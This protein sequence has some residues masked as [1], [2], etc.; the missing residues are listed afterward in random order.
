MFLQYRKERTLVSETMQRL[1][2]RG[3]TTASGGNVSLR[4]GDRICITPSQTDKGK[5]RSSEIGIV[6]IEDENLTPKL[7][8]SMEL[9]MHLEIYKSRPDIKAIVH[10]H[11]FTATALA[12]EEGLL[13]TEITGEARAILGIPAFAKYQT[14]G[15]QEL[16][17]MVAEKAKSATVILMQHHGIITLGKNMLQAFDRME[18]LEMTAR[19]L[20]IRKLCGITAKIPDDQVKILDDMFR[21]F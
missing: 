1:Y 5:I 18:V 13:G 8:P 7:K 10:A 2:W 3:L 16:A 21:N 14:M 15:T 11:P 20:V 4:V 6:T 17:D 9:R 12:A 19:T